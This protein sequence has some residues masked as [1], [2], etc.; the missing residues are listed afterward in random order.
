MAS[1]NCRLSNVRRYEGEKINVLSYYV[2][3]IVVRTTA[4]LRGQRKMASKN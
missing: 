2:A 4:T 3:K 1:E